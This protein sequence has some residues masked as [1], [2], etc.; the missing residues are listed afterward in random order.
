MYKV[1]FGQLISIDTFYCVKWLLAD[2]EGPDQTG[3]LLST[4]AKALFHLT[5]P[6]LISA[7]MSDVTESARK[8]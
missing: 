4:P 1:S 8:T 5:Q 6:T 2:S 3:P 7:E